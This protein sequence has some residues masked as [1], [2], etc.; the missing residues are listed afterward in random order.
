MEP[1]NRAFMTAPA[2]MSGFVFGRVFAH[3]AFV[4]LQL[5]FMIRALGEPVGNTDLCVDGARAHGDARLF[6]GGHDFLQAERAVAEKS[7]KSNKHGNL[8]E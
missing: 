6:T 4:T 5:P 2:R 1:L 8:R 7:D 3:Y